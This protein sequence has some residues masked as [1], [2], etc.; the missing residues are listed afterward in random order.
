[1]L[2]RMAYTILTLKCDI[3][4]AAMGDTVVFICTYSNAS[5]M[6]RVIFSAHVHTYEMCQ[7][8]SQ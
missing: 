3:E 2:P 4:M 8:Q 7:L 5:G 6:I 1:M